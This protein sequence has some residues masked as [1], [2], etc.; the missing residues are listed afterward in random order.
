[1]LTNAL[2]GWSR[3]R[4]WPANDRDAPGQTPPI[5][6]AYVHA[7][8][9]VARPASS[10]PPPE[11]VEGRPL[12]SLASPRRLGLQAA[13]FARLAPLLGATRLGLL[14]TLVEFNLGNLPVEISD[15][16]R[17]N[18]DSGAQGGVLRLDRR[19]G[20]APLPA[21]CR[22]A[23]HSQRDLSDGAAAWLTCRLLCAR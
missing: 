3:A 13:G 15:A 18:V 11:L 14:P 22:L 23:C 19:P 4:A 1:M 5:V 12:G 17:G 8:F 16:A 2:Y 9:K 7:L 6:W 10:P 21:V 20:R